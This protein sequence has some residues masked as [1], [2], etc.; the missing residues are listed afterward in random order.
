MVVPPDYH[1]DQRLVTHKLRVAGCNADLER[2]YDTFGNVIVDISLEHVD[3]EIEFTTWVV[4]EREAAVEGRDEPDAVTPDTR[5]GKPSRLTQPSRALEDVAA[6]L[7][8]TGAEGLELA[9]RIAERVHGHFVYGFGVTDVQSTAA[10]AWAGAIGVCQDYAHSMLALC[11]LCGLPARYVSGHLL[12][13]GGTHAWVE[14]L[15]PHP[16][17]PDAMRAVAIDPTHG[18]RTSLRYV[19]VAVGRDYGDVPPTS[20]TFEA[21]YPGELQTHKRAAV[22]RVEYLKPRRRRRPGALQVR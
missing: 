21:P 9:D 7:Q 12:G 13:E 14:V 18:R 17:D 15:V 20:G 11:R 16:N 3:R 8:A 6:E 2:S 22:T 4:V 10:A 1:D 5:L 19:T